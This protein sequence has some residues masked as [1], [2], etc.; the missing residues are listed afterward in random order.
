MSMPG[1]Q[2]LRSLLRRFRFEP[3]VATPGPAQPT[4][5]IGELTPFNA[6]LASNGGGARLNLVLPSINTEHYFGGIHTAV[7]LYRELCRF[8]EH[9]RIVLV[10]AAPDADAASRFPD[11]AIVACDSESDAR[12]QIVPFNDRFGRTLPVADGDTWLATAWWT[13]HAAQNVAA[14]QAH[15]YGVTRGV[16]Y[17]IQDFEPGFYPWSSQSALALST[18]RPGVD[19]AVFNTGLLAQ[20]FEREGLE[21][22]RSFC[23]EPVLHEGLRRAQAACREQPVPRSRRIIIYGRPST[24]RN[25]FELICEALRSWGWSD[26]RS[27]DWEV[28]AA[29]ELAQDI[30]L[31]S[32]RVRAVGKVGLEEYARLLSTSAIGLSLMVSP[33]PSYPP[34][35]MAAFGMGT[36]SNRFANK[37]L[38]RFSSSIRSLDRL[39]PASIAEALSEECAAW[40][41]RGMLPA[42]VMTASHPFLGESTFSSL[43]AQVHA[44]MSEPAT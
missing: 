24:P 20:Y 37:D 38:S 30:D 10:D 36:L 31:G 41:A 22:R 25:A 5:S 39:A 42:A 12:R 3:A 33:H 15:H 28:V 18:Y 13:A 32:L 14:W 35:E 34:L 26:P 21:Y 27:K 40:E 19:L 7:T 9:S 1:A 44:A 8:Y 4:T 29:G 17:L 23:F 11:H 6:R 16:A 2:R 43:A